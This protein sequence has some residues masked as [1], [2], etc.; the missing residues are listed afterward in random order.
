[1]ERG[2]GKRMGRGGMEGGECEGNMVK[3]VMIMKP[4]RRLTRMTKGKHCN[5]QKG[6]YIIEYYNP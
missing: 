2:V 4:V 6:Y 5:S 1:M 3:S